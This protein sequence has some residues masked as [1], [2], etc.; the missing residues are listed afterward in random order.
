MDIDVKRNLEA[1]KERIARAAERSGR[2]FEDIILVAVSKMVDIQRIREGIEAGLKVLGENRVQEAKEKI[3]QIE[4]DVEWHLV[5][6]LQ[7]NKA[8]DAVMLFSMIHSLD[9]LKLAKELDKRA[10]KAGKKIEV[11]VQFNLSGETTKSG[12]RDEATYNFMS[13]LASLKNIKVVG[14]MTMP[15]FFEDPDLARPYFKQLR[16]LSEEIN[17]WKLEDI[18]MKYLSMGMTGDFEVAIE[19]GANIVRIGTAI[20]GKRG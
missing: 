7:S 5:G 16:E 11:L 9:S 17:S 6:H 20:F 12:I 4:A 13:A 19:E 18:D 2:K 15:P 10:E 3:P 8:K 1:V 14:L